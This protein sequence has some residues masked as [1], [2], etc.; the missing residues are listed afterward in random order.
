MSLDC[1]GRVGCTIAW[2]TGCATWR[3]TN[4]SRTG[5]HTGPP[6]RVNVIASGGEIPHYVRDKRR[7]EAIP[8]IDLLI[9]TE[10]SILHPTMNVRAQN[11]SPMG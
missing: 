7:S 5:G 2:W 1:V 10:R 6:L 4:L 3:I 11:L 9:I 8:N